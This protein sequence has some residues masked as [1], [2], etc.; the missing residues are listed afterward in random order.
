MVKKLKEISDIKGSRK[1]KRISS[2]TKSLYRQASQQ[3]L[4]VMVK[5]KNKT[6][7]Q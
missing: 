2:A 6:G 3:V 1:I 4:E 7:R 5:M